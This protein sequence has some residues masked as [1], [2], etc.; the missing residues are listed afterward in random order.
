MREISKRWL[1]TA[2]HQHGKHS[3]VR[4][5][6]AL[7]KQ[8]V[9]GAA[10]SASAVTAVGQ[11]P[12]SAFR[13]IGDVRPRPLDEHD[14]PYT[15]E[16]QSH[17][18]F[19]VREDRFTVFASTSREDAQWAA[20]QVQ[21]AWNQAARLSARWTNAASHPD[22]GLNSLQIVIDSEPLRERDAPATTVNVVGIQTQVRIGVSQAERPLRSQMANLRAGSAFA[23]LHTAG[24][25][26]A[27]PP[28]VVRGLAEFA[29][30]QGLAE[31]LLP[32]SANAPT[33][34]AQAAMRFG[35]QQ[36]RFQRAAADALD[37]PQE[38]NQLADDRVKFLLTGNDGEHAPALLAHLR[39]LSAEAQ[40][41]AAQGGAF[42]NFGGDAQP[43]EASSSCD[44]LIAGL[45]DQF[46]QWKEKP[47][48]G[49]P[50]FEA[51]PNTTPDLLAAQREMLVLLKLQRRMSGTTAASSPRM[52]VARFD[53]DKRE[54]V[55]TSAKS[56][57]EPAKFDAW[58]ATLSD[59]AP[60]WATL[61]ADGS[62]LLKEDPRA[63]QLLSNADNRYAWKQQ[64]DHI[65]LERR[66]G[67]S[68]IVRG[69]L[70]ENTNDKTRPLARFEIVDSR[71]KKT[72]SAPG[73]L[74]LR[75]R[76]SEFRR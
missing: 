4:R 38:A 49:Q 47:L 26:S 31:E 64:A 12:L 16:T 39:V 10:V 43:P 37:E 20:S 1:A 13:S 23:M 6:L 76:V 75:P 62:L 32:P 73:P 28:W 5:M 70:E 15:R 8:L 67:D 72:H 66:L 35:G 57:A 56:T 45:G 65:V 48:A 11:E 33:S 51:A 14:R 50:V 25:D 69:W 58:A 40:G 74:S 3:H 21:E 61:D 2:T 42:R 60:P 52:K 36:W 22:F 24:V 68:R 63:R 18:G 29:A 27:A 7:G 17:R 54:V 41:R 19:E 46:T 30:R 9:L 53:R 55:A 44:A 71:A 59:T 34:G